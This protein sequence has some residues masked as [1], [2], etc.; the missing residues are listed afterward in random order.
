MK[1]FQGC[2]GSKVFNGMKYLQAIKKHPK[3]RGK[4]LGII[5]DTKEKVFDATEK[6]VLLFILKRVPWQHY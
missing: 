5:L 1:C 4:S 6:N 3:H 2:T